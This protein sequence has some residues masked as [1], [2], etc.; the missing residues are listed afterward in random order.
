MRMMRVI[1]VGVMAVVV[2]MF[3]FVFVVLPRGVVRRVERRGRNGVYVQ[4]R[5]CSCETLGF[6]SDLS[7]RYLREREKE[8]GNTMSGGLQREKRG[9]E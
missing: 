5:R 6:P 3:V 8:K 7:P 1:V 2:V 4:P 9:A